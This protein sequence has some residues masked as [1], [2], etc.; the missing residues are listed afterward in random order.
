MV[1]DTPTT[2]IMTLVV[3]TDSSKAFNKIN[4]I[5]EKQIWTTNTKTNKYIYFICKEDFLELIY[6]IAIVTQ[7]NNTDIDYTYR[8]ENIF[9][10]STWDIGRKKR[11]KKTYY[12]D[13][14]LFTY[15]K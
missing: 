9:M 12:L 7:S 5:I 1:H 10:V 4:A 8:K 15:L 2:N 6:N 11:Y 3:S 13:D 14:N